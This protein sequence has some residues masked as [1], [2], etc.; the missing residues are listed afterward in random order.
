MEKMSSRE[1]CKLLENIVGDTEPVADSTVDEIREKNLMTLID[2]GDWV[3]DGLYCVA[4]HR[5]DPYY[6]CQN[7]GERAY[8][9]MLEWKEWLLQKEEELA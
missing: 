7:A 2:I 9:T 6:S 4:L 8:A 5:K 3:L 1:I